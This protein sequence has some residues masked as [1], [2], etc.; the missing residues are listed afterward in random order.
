[1]KTCGGWLWLVL[2]SVAGLRGT[3]ANDSQLNPRLAEYVAQRESEFDQIGAERK[4]QLQLLADYLRERRAA[5]KPIQLTFICTHNS[6]RSHMSQ[7][8][9]QVA[10]V[11]YGLAKVE[12]F[13]GGT[14]S[15]AFN[16]RAVDALR[17]AGFDIEQL[18]KSK[19]PR[20][21]VAF[22]AG[23]HPVVCFSKIYTEA[24]NPKSDFCA[25]LTCSSADRACPTVSGASLRV[26]IP[27]ED[28][29]VAD[30]TPEEAII[31]D[32]R[33]AQIARELLYAFSQAR[34]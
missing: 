32:E 31:Y 34:S 19:N 23:S 28:P 33:A 8:W 30:D 21:Q 17:R 2:I 7:L 3:V 16:P 29:K 9:G 26:A 27:Y 18:D 22:A 14:E 10:A 13:S 24:P 12:T 6:R 20:Y 5:D 4:A 25:V 1:M 15:T 11:H